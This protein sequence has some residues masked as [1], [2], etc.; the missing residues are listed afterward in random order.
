M[1]KRLEQPRYLDARLE[2]RVLGL[3]VHVLDD[4][5]G[6]LLQQIQRDSSVHVV[7]LNAEMAMQ[8]EGDRDSPAGQRNLA[9]II[10]GAE[11]VV[12]DGSGVV[13]YLRLRNQRIQ[14]CPGIELSESLIRRLGASPD[15]SIFFY[16]GEPGVAQGAAQRWQARCPQLNVAGAEHGYISPEEQEALC[17][18]LRREQPAVIFVGLGVPRQE[19]WIDRHRHLCPRSIW[20]GVGGSLDIWAGTKVRAPA[21]LR[22]NHLEWSYRLYKE[23]WRWRRMLVLPQ[24]AWRALTAP[25]R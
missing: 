21:W 1:T 20:V 23:P 25:R 15:H 9:D 16:G 4:Y 8:A 14:R 2:M 13:L 5:A 11:L 3:P 7:T 18:R 6:W 19:F 24:F 17:D 12:P 22:N 10:C